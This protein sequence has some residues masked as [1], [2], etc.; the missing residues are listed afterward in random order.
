MTNRLSKKIIETN[1]NWQPVYENIYNN[2]KM[3]FCGVSN[4][5]EMISVLYN[6]DY[7]DI[8][9]YDI[10]IYSFSDGVPVEYRN[11]KLIFVVNYYVILLNNG[12]KI[13]SVGYCEGDVLNNYFYPNVIN[14][15]RAQPLD[16]GNF[17]YQEQKYADVI[18][19]YI[20]RNNV[21]VEDYDLEY[22]SNFTYGDFINKDDEL[23][24]YLK[25]ALKD[26][27]PTKEYVDRCTY[28]YDYNKLKE[29][30][31]K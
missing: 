2:H 15:R 31:V 28:Y 30:L 18:D 19:Y 26:D 16:Y 13:V 1:P 11:S 9:D 12:R 17:I 20:L 6:N 27:T 21:I 23:F 25:C 29:L 22:I 10:S 5:H 8:N 4:I 7:I 3:A 24:E 14:T